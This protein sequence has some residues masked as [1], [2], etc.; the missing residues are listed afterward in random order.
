MWFGGVV[1]VDILILHTPLKVLA[2]DQEYGHGSYD[3][4]WEDLTTINSVS[5]F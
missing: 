4:Q 1:D 3:W 5:Y 2:H